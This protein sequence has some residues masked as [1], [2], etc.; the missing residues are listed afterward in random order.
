MAKSLKKQK[1][2]K[3]LNI[4]INTDRKKNYDDDINK[5]IM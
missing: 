1:C 3:F 2:E 4:C 5:N